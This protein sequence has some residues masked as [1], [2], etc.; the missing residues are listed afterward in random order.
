MIQLSKAPSL[1]Q[2]SICCE[3]ALLQF[4]ASKELLASGVEASAQAVFMVRAPLPS[5]SALFVQS[6]IPCCRL[7]LQGAS[8][9]ACSAMA[10]NVSLLPSTCRA[11]RRPAEQKVSAEAMQWPSDTNLVAGLLAGAQHFPKKKLFC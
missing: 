6:C 10:N 11:H 4:A 3:H 8:R 5:G 2:R 9:Q 7:P 1:H